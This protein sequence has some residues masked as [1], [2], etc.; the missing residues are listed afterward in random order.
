VDPESRGGRVVKARALVEKETLQ[1]TL[2]EKKENYKKKAFSLESLL[3]TWKI[4][5]FT[6][7]HH[8]FRLKMFHLQTEKV[9]P[10][11]EH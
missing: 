5:F 2:Q 9:N 6:A 11:F 7:S 1:F 10:R 4:N 8:V 3:K